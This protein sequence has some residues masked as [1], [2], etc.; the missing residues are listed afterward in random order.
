M[1]KQSLARLPQ[2]PT[3][4][5]ISG[6]Q[7][8]HP[9]IITTYCL[10]LLLIGFV[11]G[12]FGY[13]LIASLQLILLILL[14]RYAPTPGIIW[15][16]VFSSTTGLFQRLTLY[17]SGSYPQSDGIRFALE[18]GIL[19]YFA[20]S[21]L[22]Y[23]HA[24]TRLT[25][26]I[27]IA[28]W[29]YLIFAT[30]YAFNLFYT[31][32]LVT[33]WGW[34]WICIPIF[35]YFIGRQV[36][37]RPVNAKLIY[38]ALVIALLLQS[39]YGAFQSIV[40]IPF[41]E[42]PWV[43]DL[44]VRET[45]T[46]SVEGSMFLAGKPRIP[47]LTEGHTSGAFL[48]PFLFLWVLF[49][50]R[51]AFS[52][53]FQFLRLVAILTSSLFFIFSNERSAIG[54]AGIGVI[55]GII[56]KLRRKTGRG[57]Y[58]LIVPGMIVLIF[59]LSLIDPSK[60]PWAEDTI[61]LRRLAELANP[62]RSGTLEGRLTEYWPILWKLFLANPLGYGLG[63]FHDTS[64]NIAYTQRI[65]FSPHNMYLQILLEFGII[66]FISFMS[67]IVL[68]GKIVYRFNN[69]RISVESIKIMPSVLSSISAFLAI[70][71]ANQPIE[72]FPLAL[73]FWFLMGV[74]ISHIEVEY[75]KYKER[76]ILP[77]YID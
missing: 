2:L 38:Q 53:R 12:Q 14:S 19:V 40:G 69:L 45:A 13:L 67:I 73:L 49:L 24:T 68:F 7:L 60:I 11:G 63:T 43:A 37:K 77:S 76:L 26:R 4:L 33:I 72:T 3:N 32:P 9:L 58:L 31:I 71:F 70:G 6:K 1:V 46:A 51:I 34:R 54:M 30:I 62:F 36:A 25:A 55:V 47:A 59:F 74:T 23:Q 20:R 28:V 75:A 64:A 15:L 65:G 50:P 66:G 61:L 17:S 21:I 39:S 18:I 44:F 56:L 29:L 57:I 35:L 5:K 8:T 22:M 48:I 42:R 41:Y 16:I 27:D 52:K 10:T